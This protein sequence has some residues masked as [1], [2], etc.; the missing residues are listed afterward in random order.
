[1]KPFADKRIIAIVKILE[2]QKNDEDNRI[3]F[4]HKALASRITK[5]SD[6]FYW[7][8]DCHLNTLPPDVRLLLQ[9]FVLPIELS[10][11]FKALTR[12]TSKGPQNPSNH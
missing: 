9:I 12:L 4:P 8:N 7:W 3:V 2:T 11:V 1:M 5:H 6:S 10:V